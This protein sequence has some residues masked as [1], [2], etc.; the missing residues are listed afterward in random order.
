MNVEIQWGTMPREVRKV[1]EPLFKKNLHLLPGWC[2][3]LFIRYGDA[4][5]DQDRVVAYIEVDAE[6]LQASITLCRR[7]LDD[8]DV[9]RER[10]VIHE[11]LHVS[12]RPLQDW[13]E[14]FMSIYVADEEQDKWRDN[15]NHKAI[16]SVIQNLMFSLVPPKRD[17]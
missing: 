4:P 14:H 2:R 6:Y 16:E 5:K 10:T 12:M 15:F 1:A 13:V 3:A 7:F 17:A 9:N 11:L 8:T